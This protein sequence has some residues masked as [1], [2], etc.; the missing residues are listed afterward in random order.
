MM[1]STWWPYPV[2]PP[3]GPTRW[4]YLVALHDGLH[5]VALPGGSTRW[6]H[7]VAL[8]GVGST[9]WLH[10]MALPGGPT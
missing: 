3:G 6:L 4:L 7:P 8:P 2:A 10:M 5:L 1:G 9:R